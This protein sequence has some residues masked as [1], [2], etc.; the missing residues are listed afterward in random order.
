M[1]RINIGTLGA[2]AALS[3]ALTLALSSCGDGEITGGGGNSTNISVRN[4]SFSPSTSTVPAGT[5]VTWTWNSGGTQH[6]VTFADGPTSPNQSGGG[7][8][9]RQFDV[10]GTY[11]YQCTLHAAMSGTIVAE[12]P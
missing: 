10:A 4:N 8:Y 11:G 3:L 2:L 5:V 1:A 9:Q 12:A 7:T 6:N